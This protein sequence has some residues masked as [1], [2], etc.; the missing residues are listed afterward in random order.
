MSL[1]KL[2][3]WHR[4]ACYSYSNANDIV[5]VFAL[6]D[7]LYDSFRLFRPRPSGG[8]EAVPSL[9]PLLCTSLFADTV[10]DCAHG[11]LLLPAMVT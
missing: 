5:D 11:K 7:P 1:I 10:A 3:C 8:V 9:L 4:I 2:T 6:L